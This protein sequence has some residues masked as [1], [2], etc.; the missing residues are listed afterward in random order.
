VRFAD[1]FWLAIQLF[2]LFCFFQEQLY[3]L[4]LAAL[5]LCVVGWISK[6]MKQNIGQLTWLTELK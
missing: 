2:G 4:V 6:K 1:A 3:P 5:L